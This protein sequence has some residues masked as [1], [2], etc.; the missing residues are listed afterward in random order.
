[1]SECPLCKAD[2]ITKTNPHKWKCGTVESEEIHGKY[3]QSIACELRVKLAAAEQERDALA[4]RV[5]ELEAACTEVMVW[6]DSDGSVGGLDNVIHDFRMV[7]QKEFFEP[8]SDTT[9]KD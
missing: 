1:M 7:A 6:Y 2:I 3:Y 4:T 8:S 5:K 9:P